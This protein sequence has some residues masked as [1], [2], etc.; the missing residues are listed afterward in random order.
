M[1]NF[2]YLHITYQDITNQNTDLVLDFKL[3]DTEITKKWVNRVLLAQQLGYPIDNPDRFYGFDSIE[4]QIHKAL[5]RINT[6]VDTLESK[7][8][9]P[10]GRRL[11]SVDD[12]DTLNFLHHIFEIQHGLLDKKDIDPQLQE[13]LCNL[14][15]MVHH[16]ESIQRGALPRHVVTYFGLPKTE[17]LCADD[18]RYFETSIK[19]GT[20]YIN[21]A[22]I[23]KTLYDLWMD[24]D[25]Y[26]N[27]EAF[28]PFTHYSADFTVKFWNDSQNTLIM[29]L[30]NYYV[31]HQQF[32]N[33]LEY[34][35][36]ELSKTIGSIPIA[37]LVG[38]NA[39][40]LLDALKLRQYVKAVHFS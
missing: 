1:P 2:N 39:D 24:N 17:T 20:V 26:I 4:T 37:D 30:K 13:S 38:I 10:I 18:Y 25:R 16:C 7:W 40:T 6:I 9:I 15:I 8:D 14:N 28:Q 23:G 29:D 33:S 35:W 32:F 22:E 5:H 19:S 34:S 31:I 11:S 21:Y 3:R 27:P 36:E 12:Q